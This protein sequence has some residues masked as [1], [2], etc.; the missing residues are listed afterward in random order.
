MLCDLQGQ[1]WP[2][3]ATLNG[4]EKVGKL[5]SFETNIHNWPDDGYSGADI[6]SFICIFSFYPYFSGWP[7]A[8]AW[9]SKKGSRAGREQ[10]KWEAHYCRALHPR[11]SLVS[12]GNGSLSCTVELQVQIQRS[13]S[14]SLAASMAVRRAPCSEAKG[15]VTAP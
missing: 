10:D 5:A 8:L 3:F 9:H 2:L 13:W 6:C 14:V 1:L 11:R 12:L 15:S 7:K 4:V